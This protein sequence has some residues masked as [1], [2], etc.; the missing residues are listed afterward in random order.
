MPQI[1][2]HAALIR[3]AFN[4]RL[5]LS[6]SLIAFS[7]AMD[8]F[9]HK[10]GSYN[11]TAKAWQVEPEFLSLL[12]SL[13]YVGFVIGLFIGSTI[14]ARWGRRMTMFS[15][16]IYA[17]ATVPITVTSKT[18]AQILTART[19][20]YAYLGMELAVVPVFQAEIV[21]AS[22]R[23]LVVATYQLAIYIGGLI[24]SIVC[25]A[26]SNLAGDQQWQ[27]PLGLFA[28]IPAIVAGLV[29]FIPESPRWLLMHGRAEESFAA[30]KKL[31]EGSF[32]E[33]ET[34]AEFDAL[35]LLLSEEH[36]KGKYKE[37]FQGPNL[38]RTLISIGINVF[39]QITGQVFAAR[40][41]TVYIKSLGTVNAFTMTIVN[42]VVCLL[43]VLF[44]MAL[45]DKLGRRPL[46]MFSGAVQ[47]VSLYGMA[48]LDTPAVVT[49]QMKIGVVAFF[50]V[51]NFGFCSGWAPLSHTLSAEIPTARLRDMTYRTAS[52]VNIVLTLV[53]S[54]I[55][56]YLLNAPY[57]NLGSK[58]GYIFGSTS[59]L[60]IIF[61]Y[62]CVPECKGKTLE[63][64][65]RLFLDGVPLRQFQQT[66]VVPELD[67][68][69]QT[70][71]VHVER[72]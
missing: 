52:T 12:N 51:F 28:V 21:P 4:L 8:A 47:A 1:V 2:E 7:Q 5:L 56:P 10:F 37:I 32:T 23:G 6:V 39:L 25:Q 19:L 63:E 53:M 62:Y 34:A 3:Q 55:I 44:S 50:C 66:T 57:A 68:K 43:G 11:K 72:V 58:V 40:Y 45:T 33:E 15:M 70:V 49:R 65:D 42:Q 69:E 17:M 59:I 31:R 38:K 22:V 18:K 41:G 54:R 67:E 20:N 16:S 48:G 30:L 60:A 26:T 24:M 36:E 46:L 35:Q 64:L 13:P 14:S 71:G 27:I 29:W 9:A 61:T